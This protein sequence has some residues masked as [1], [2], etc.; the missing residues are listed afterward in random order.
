MRPKAPK[1]FNRKHKIN[2]F[3]LHLQ[4]NDSLGRDKGR[5]AQVIRESICIPNHLPRQEHIDDSIQQPAAQLLSIPHLHLV[6][7]KRSTSFF[8]VRTLIRGRTKHQASAQRPRRQSEQS[9]HHSH[10]AR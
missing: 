5:F 6:I 8:K 10:Q 9:K 2:A 4:P 1:S 7:R 3:K